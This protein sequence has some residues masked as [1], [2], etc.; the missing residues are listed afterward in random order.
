MAKTKKKKKD[1]ADGGQLSLSSLGCSPAELEQLKELLV[2]LRSGSPV[3][4]PVANSSKESCIL[5]PEV[6]GVTPPEKSPSTS[7]KVNP[8][9]GWH[10]Q[11]TTKTTKTDVAMKSCT[12]GI[13]LLSPCN[14]SAVSG[15]SELTVNKA[16]VCLASVEEAK[17]AIAELSSPLPMAMLVP[18]RIDGRGVEQPVLVKKTDGQNATWTRLLIQLGKEDVVFDQSKVPVGGHVGNTNVRV[19]VYGKEGKTPD[20]LWQSF[21]SSPKA[22]ADRWLKNTAGLSECGRIQGPR[23]VEDTLSIVVEVPPAMVEKV[24][25]ASAEQGVFS[26]EFLDENQTSKTRIVPVDLRHDRMAAL[27]VA[28]SLQGKA[29]GVVPT[30]KGWGIRVP[31]DSFDAVLAEVNPDARESLVGDLY[32]VS[33]LPLSWNRDNVK[34]F[35]G[36]WSATP[37]GRPMRVGFRQTFTVRAKQ[38][39]PT[40]T[41]RNPDPLGL[42]V[43]ALISLKEHRPNKNKTVMTF[44][45]KNKTGPNSSRAA[46]SRTW[47]D[48]VKSPATAKLPETRTP[49]STASATPP[50]GAAR[51]LDVS[52]LTAPSHTNDFMMQLQ[53]MMEAIVA[54]I[55]NEI[56]QMKKV[57]EEDLE[58]QMEADEE[59]SDAEEQEQQNS[60]KITEKTGPQGER[61]AGA[62]RPA[63]PNGEPPRGDLRQSDNSRSPRRG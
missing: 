49:A 2:L 62:R 37:V 13:E 56:T 47:V 14:A 46:A 28:Q 30:K 29:F 16:C 3:L 25:C 32:T 57:M 21:R 38:P 50:G 24:L 58:D 12:S 48:A 63:E 54:P 18:I 8:T 42:N 59:E 20:D 26:R 11:K 4:K 9:D 15:V 31:A 39:P 41:L 23:L 43:L 60:E 40:T 27:R 10:V 7:A 1:G 61:L 53:K 33:G 51:T 6:S 34:A 5:K 35:L 19:V 45:P 44:R 17:K 22:I 52:V 55:Q 36:S